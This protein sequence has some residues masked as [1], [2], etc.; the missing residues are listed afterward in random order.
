MRCPQ[1]FQEWFF[2]NPERVCGIILG[3]II[4][5]MQSG[6]NII[7]QLVFDLGLCSAGIAREMTIEGRSWNN[8]TRK[9]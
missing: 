7:S 1:A 8:S 2:A 4:N 3:E 9:K 6:I 5:P